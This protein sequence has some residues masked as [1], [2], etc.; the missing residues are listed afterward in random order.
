[1]DVEKFKAKGDL[2]AFKGKH[3]GALSG[4]FLALACRKLSHGRLADTKMLRQALVST[5][6]RARAGLTEARDL[7][8][9]QT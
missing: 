8:K 1:M 9:V 4:Y 5:W 3:P 6:E 2:L 7:R